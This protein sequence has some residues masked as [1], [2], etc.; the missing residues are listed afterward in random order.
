MVQPAAAQDLFAGGVFLVPAIG[1]AICFLFLLR[2]RLDK[3][4]PGMQTAIAERHK[5]EAEACGE[6][7]V[8]PE[9][10]ER[11]EQIELDRVAE[12]KRINEL[13]ALCEKKG[14]DFETEE[15]KYQAKL[16]RKAARK[17]KK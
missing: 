7:Y 16:A 8:S 4:L 3:E 12:E 10:K 1:F 2:Y 14:L 11:L 6:V 9:E 13:K 5:A 15:A 17:A